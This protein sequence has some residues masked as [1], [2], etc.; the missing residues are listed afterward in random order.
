MHTDIPH[1]IR[2]GVSGDPAVKANEKLSQQI[3]AALVTDLLSLYD[4]ES[5]KLIRSC[6]HTP[7]AFTVLTSPNDGAQSLL[8]NE[9]LKL[10]HSKQVLIS[11]QED[12][13]HYIVDHCDVVMI[14]GDGKEIVPYAKSR[15]RPLVQISA[16]DPYQISVEKG[17]GLNAELISRIETYNT[18][19]IPGDAWTKYCRNVFRDH[20]DKPE[21]K[22]IAEEIKAIVRKDLIP[23]YVRASQIA[24]ANQK[25]Y[26]RA[27]LVAYLLAAGAV[28][29]VAAGT[30][31]HR[32]SAVS[33]AFEL[34][35]LILI[36]SVIYF[37]NRRRAHKKWIES[38]FLAEHIRSAMFLYTCGVEASPILVPPY[39][40]VAHRTDDWM[41][42]TFQEIW[43]RL[44]APKQC[45]END[46]AM[47]SDFAR[48]VWI[49]DQL[50][51]HERKS[52]SMGRLSH[53]LERTGMILFAIALTAA[54][55][56][57]LLYLLGYEARLPGL[58]R[59]LTFL[60]IS[61][62]AAAA[63]MEG[64]RAHREYSRLAR[65]SENMA[66]ALKD[67]DQRLQGVVSPQAMESLLREAEELMLRETQGWLM[68]MRFVK[69]EAVL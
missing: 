41:V 16:A 37:A 34:F 14:L 47:L 10:P 66:V 43:E 54:S 40:G 35:L 57:I 21:A 27:G 33:F 17:F 63:A 29:S 15:S 60:A 69:L 50:R 39:M 42:L 23:H 28:A 58:E 19:S 31:F 48:N 11:K 4:E 25:T 3:R 56:H 67:L 9:I 26:H 5:L 24:K 36:L 45:Q 1:R 68:L 12:V 22:P 46:C 6:T 44:P 61:L 18:F 2:I 51:Y 38:R 59:V 30:V 49:Q 62:P 64:I 32:Y 65:F 55:T 53:R 13:A 7:L 8:A 20:F 52:R